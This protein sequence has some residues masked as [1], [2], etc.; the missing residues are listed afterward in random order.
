M[1]QST[2]SSTAEDCVSPGA[3]WWTEV[4]H[5][6][7]SPKTGARNESSALRSQE[8]LQISHIGM[9][10]GGRWEVEFTVIYPEGL[11]QDSH[12]H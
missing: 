9:I 4:L 8:F 12:S 10:P 2:L 3:F 7:V 5:R 11:I 6:D 1:G